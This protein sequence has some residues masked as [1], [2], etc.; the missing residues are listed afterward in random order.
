MSYTSQAYGSWS[1]VYWIVPV[2]M[3]TSTNYERTVLYVQN[4]N[5]GAQLTNAKT[6]RAIQ[7]VAGSLDPQDLADRTLINNRTF[8]V[9]YAE[10]LI[11]AQSAES[12]R[13]PSPSVVAG[14]SSEST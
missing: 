14:S 1:I 13:Q 8:L 2:K 9:A 4:S 6:G 10:K 11:E 3:G 5:G 12:S 7:N